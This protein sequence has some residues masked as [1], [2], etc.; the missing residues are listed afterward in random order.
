MIRRCTVTHHSAYPTYGGRGIKVCERWLVY[1]SFYED[2]SPTWFPGATIDRIDNDGDYTPENCQWLT[3]SDN[4]KKASADRKAKG[5][6]VSVETRRKMSEHNWARTRPLEH[7]GHMARI[8]RYER[9]F[10]IREKARQALLGRTVLNK[11]ETR[12]KQSESAS[13]R[14]RVVC[15]FCGKESA[16]NNY[17]RFHGVKCKHYSGID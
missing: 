6:S 10:E 15:E 16:V 17:H 9:T 11:E 4:A 8:A 3:R 5:H 1:E 14:R 12:K 13:R 2:M 7:S